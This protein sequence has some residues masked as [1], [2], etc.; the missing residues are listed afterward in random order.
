MRA[1]PLALEAGVTVGDASTAPYSVEKVMSCAHSLT[2][3]LVTSPVRVVA[4]TIVC[5]GL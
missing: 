1:N 3:Y 5:V 4:Q 2:V